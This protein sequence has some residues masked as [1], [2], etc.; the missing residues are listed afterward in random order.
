[1]YDYG[2]RFYMP[3]I[4]RWGVVDPLAESYR[5][6]SPYNYAVNN[7][8][9]FVDPDGRG[10]EYNWGTGD[11]ESVDSNGTR[12]TLDEWDAMNYLL[13]QSY[14][15]KAYR[16]NALGAVNQNSGGN[17]FLVIDINQIE[18]D[19]G[20]K[21]P[22][23]QLEINK[24]LAVGLISATT[25]KLWL[26][27][28]AVEGAGVGVISVGSAASSGF[29]WGTFATVLTRAISIGA[30]LSIK[31]EAPPQRYYVYGISGSERM[32]K[33]GITRQSD[34]ANRP[35]SQIA[36]LNKKFVDD[37]P[38]SWKFLQGPVDIGGT[39]IGIQGEKASQFIDM[40]RDV[41][42][43]YLNIHSKNPANMEGVTVNKTIMMGPNNYIWSQYSFYDIH[44][45]KYLGG[46]IFD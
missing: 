44:S 1:M 39:I 40:Y 6:H 37:G 30:L 31:D 42:N 12:T 8:I 14:S 13:S 11:Y 28:I 3:D 27:S 22:F 10:V 18:N 36:M 17:S 35:E 19:P 45:H 7:P 5:R 46:G 43:N 38:H 24:L 4:G 15:V 21:H 41:Q 33:F 26:S 34:P 20:P 29:T 25:A 23:S 2:A 32:A 16:T 9:V